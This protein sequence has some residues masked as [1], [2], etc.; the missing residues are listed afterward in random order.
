MICRPT[1]SLVTIRPFYSTLLGVC[2]WMF[3]TARSYAS[4]LYAVVVYPSV[5]TLDT[6]RH[7]TKTSK[8]RIM[9]TTP[10]I[11]VKFQQSH[12]LRVGRVGLNWRFSTLLISQKRWNYGRSYYGTLI[13]T[14]MRCIEWR[15]FQWPWVTPNYPKPPHF[16]YFASPFVSS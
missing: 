13:G 15:Y 1:Y 12:P 7:C 2:C 9:Q 8:R 6:S 3:F 14:R 10:K 5:C 11:L 4:A 16:R